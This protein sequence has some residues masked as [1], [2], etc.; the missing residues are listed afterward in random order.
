MTPL[1]QALEYAVNLPFRIND[2][3]RTGLAALEGQVMRLSFTKPAWV[4]D[5]TFGAHHITVAAPNGACHVALTGSPSQFVALMRA[6]PERTQEIMAKGLRIEGDIECAFA[7]KR[8][9]ARAALDWEDVLASTVGDVPAHLF[10]QG[11][12]WLR[13]STRYAIRG[14]ATNAVEFIQEEAAALPR[15]RDLDVFLAEVD[16]LRDDV[17]RL[18]QRINR[19]TDRR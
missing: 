13:E 7:I 2:D 6:E 14:I 12:Q 5:F 10:A 3:A 4:A 1:F 19:L 18:A 11:F 9:F 15:P 8:L 16:T 17:E